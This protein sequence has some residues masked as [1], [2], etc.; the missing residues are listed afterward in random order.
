MISERASRIQ[1]SATLSITAMAKKMKKQGEDIVILGAGEPDF[2]TPDNIKDAASKAIKEGFTKYTAASGIDELKTAICEKFEKDNNISYENSNILISCGAK[3]SLYNIMQATL[4]AGDEV[5]LPVPYWVSYYEQIRLAEAKPVFVD[6]DENFEFT[7]NVFEKAITPKTR[8][9]V[10]N[11]PSNPSGAVIPKS[12]LKKIADVAVQ[13]N[14]LVLADEVYEKICYDSEHYSIA[15]LNDEIKELTIT[16]NAVSKTYSMTGWRVGYCAARNDIIKAASNIQSHSTSNPC[17]IAQKAALEAITG[18]QD[19]VKKM[20]EAFR[21]RRELV[22]S[23][24]NTIPGVDCKKPAGSFYVF[25]D[26]SKCYNEVVKGSVDFAARL[27]EKEKVAVIPGEAFGADKNIRISYATSEEQIG[28]GID[29]IKH[30]VE[31]M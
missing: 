7:A 4:N 24:L 14:I 2:D 31:N 22:V 8:M 1:P 13:N 29:R 30:F 28:K 9:V 21:K 10:L 16:F 26:V 25:P 20:V 23:K 27:L 5:I 3:H 15:A 18:P 17:S 12:E 19:S 11:Y 6:T